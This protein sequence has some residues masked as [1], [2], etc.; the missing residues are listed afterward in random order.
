MECGIKSDTSV[1]SIALE[2]RRTF[3]ELFCLLCF[4][5]YWS[6]ANVEIQYF[7]RMGRSRFWT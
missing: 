7:D 6:R 2:K 4:Q 5:Y 1:S 3:E